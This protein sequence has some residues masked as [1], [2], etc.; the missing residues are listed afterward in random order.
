M[1]NKILMLE[2]INLKTYDGATAHFWGVYSGFKKL[3]IYP[4]VLLP[5]PYPQDNNFK[6]DFLFYPS[7]GDY[8]KKLS[9]LRYLIS[10]FY[11]IK[12]MVKNKINIIYCRYTPLFTL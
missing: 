4:I 9:K 8:S 11:F 5:K 12:I 10:L 6:K 2:D 3:N 7:F 1:S